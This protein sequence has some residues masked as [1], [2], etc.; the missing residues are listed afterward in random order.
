MRARS[1]SLNSRGQ[2]SSSDCSYPPTSSSRPRS[3]F[4]QM[5]QKQGVLTLG[6]DTPQRK[7]L[8]A[9]RVVWYALALVALG[10][11]Y[12][13]GS[14]HHPTTQP[15]TTSSS[16][17]VSN[18]PTSEVVSGPSGRVHSF[19]GPSRSSLEAELLDSLN[20]QTTRRIPSHSA[21][22]AR[23]E[24]L[25]PHSAAQAD[26]LQIQDFGPWWES[27]SEAELGAGRLRL[28]E[29]VARGFGFELDGTGQGEV[30]EEDW[31]LQFGDGR[32]GVVY[33]K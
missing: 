31:E 28:A 16:S 11:L 10:S 2:P 6:T 18:W 19:S 25:C 29:A 7:P 27:A 12:H 30:R 20:N 32:R 33:S 22:L 21:S 17:F 15:T 13:L 24:K 26:V 9:R 4:S 5:I 1:A 14:A 3:F 23:Q 8:A